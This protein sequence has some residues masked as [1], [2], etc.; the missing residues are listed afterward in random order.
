MK[1]KGYD[2]KKNTW[3]VGKTLY[4]VYGDSCRAIMDKFDKKQ[5][6][7]KDESEDEEFVVERI[8]KKRIGKNGKTEYT[9]SNTIL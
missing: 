8:V 4:A 1:L 5:Q 3:E 2:E 6:K 7:D 9:I